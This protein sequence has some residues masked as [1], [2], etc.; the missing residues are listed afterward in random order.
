MSGL[1]HLS[2]RH[3][4]GNKSLKGKLLLLEVLGRTFGDFKSSHGFGDGL[5][6][7]L[8][9]AT[10]ELERQSRVG[11]NLLHT[12]NVGLELLLGFKSLAECLIVA[13]ESLGVRDHLFDLTSGELADRVGNSDVGT[14]AR[15]LLSGGDL[16]DTINIHFE[17][18]L[19]DGLASTHGRNGSKSELSQRGVVLT[20]DAL[21]L[22]DG[23][24]NGLL[25]VGNGSEGSIQGI[26]SNCY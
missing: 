17:D 13:L 16:Q 25:V 8:L 9:L 11:D 23:E 7:L 19:E 15:G 20:V 26:V 10:L 4:L 21:T 1:I 5:L 22:V 6:N 12:A 14:A 24:L 18:T 3:G 2:G